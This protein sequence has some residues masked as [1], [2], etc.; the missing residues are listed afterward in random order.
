MIIL[1]KRF[2]QACFFARTAFHFHCSLCYESHIQ[3]DDFADIG[4]KKIKIKEIY[5]HQI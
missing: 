4:R 5:D 3:S 1:E 2:S